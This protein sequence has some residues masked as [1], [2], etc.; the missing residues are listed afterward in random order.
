MWI[1]VNG[2]EFQID[3]SS[4]CISS[5]LILRCIF[6]HVLSWEKAP[7]RNFREFLTLWWS[8]F[9]QIVSTHFSKR[10]RLFYSLKHRNNM[11][12]SHKMAT[13]SLYFGVLPAF[14]HPSWTKKNRKIIACIVV[15]PCIHHF[16]TKRSHQIEGKSLS[17]Y[18]FN[19]RY[20]CA[21]FWPNN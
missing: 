14:V 7:S 3:K 16:I 10:G 15:T 18:T 8:A 5:K 1:Q 21:F 19:W 20:N 9:K 2:F 17:T 4:M 11:T 12:T 13:N 6:L